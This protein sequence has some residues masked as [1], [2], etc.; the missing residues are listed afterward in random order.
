VGICSRYPTV[1]VDAVLRAQ[2]HYLHYF[3]GPVWVMAWGLVGVHRS[4]CLR[5]FCPNHMSVS[6]ILFNRFRD[7]VE[8]G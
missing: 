7:G 3:I 5:P 2:N 4:V 8:F 6:L 1:C